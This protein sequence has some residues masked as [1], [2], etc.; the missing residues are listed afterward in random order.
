MKH[1]HFPIFE[2]PKKVSPISSVTKTRSVIRKNQYDINVTYNLF[3]L[4][5]RWPIRL[6]KTYV[7]T[8]LE[9]TDLDY[10]IKM[11]NNFKSNKDLLYDINLDKGHMERFDEFRKVYDKQLD[12][13]C[14]C[15]GMFTSQFSYMFYIGLLIKQNNP[16]IDIIV[17]GSHI[18]DS[19]LTVELFE[20]I[21]IFD[22]IIVGDIEEAICLYEENK[23][24][25]YKRYNATYDLKKIDIPIYYPN[26]IINYEHI[27]VETSR[28]CINKC[29]FCSNYKDIYRKIPIEIIEK[30]FL[31]YND[32]N[33]T[34][35]VYIQAS[36]INIHNREFIKI[37]DM[38]NRI[39]NRLLIHSFSTFTE[40]DISFL[41]SMYSAGFRKLFFGL[42]AVHSE[43]RKML[44]IENKI[45]DNIEEIIE[46]CIEK[47]IMISIPLIWGFPHETREVFDYEMKYIKDLYDRYPIKL[48][49]TYYMHKPGSEIYCDIE[50]YGI[51]YIYWD[52]MKCYDNM[53]NEIITRVPKLYKC[54][55]PMDEFK[56]R[57]DSILKIDNRFR[58]LFTENL[59]DGENF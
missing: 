12:F 16:N 46:A 47:N 6:N 24:T 15:L 32:Y 2:Y 22:Y 13:D 7:R 59:W 8:V 33:N 26:E 35:G 31:T 21:K 20:F 25:K 27:L 54:N 5:Y 44:N 36:S 19:N 42:D 29:G 34:T 57:Y 11:I 58:S 53:L 37:V 55:I 48:F 4:K 50:K 45:P 28:G 18:I 56:C 1:I 23:L 17:G 40:F 30:S 49:V 14:V 51:E 43:K 3:E 10:I 38:L 9:I 39:N 52:E 41:D